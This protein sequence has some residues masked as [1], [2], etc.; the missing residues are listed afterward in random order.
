MPNCC[1][2][3]PE[4]P[5]PKCFA[6]VRTCSIY[7]VF[8][9][10]RLTLSSPSNTSLFRLLLPLP[11]S[12]VFSSFSPSSSSVYFANLT[13]V[14]VIAPEPGVRAGCSDRRVV[15]FNLDWRIKD[16]S[17]DATATRIYVVDE[18]GPSIIR[19]SL[20]SS[21]NVLD[22]GI[23]FD[24][25][26][27]EGRL[28]DFGWITGIRYPFSTPGNNVRTGLV[29]WLEE[30]ERGRRIKLTDAATPGFTHVLVS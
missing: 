30:D 12:Y 6:L 20:S 21:G 23:D 16:L 27:I 28:V 13:H 26:E 1:F 2:L 29:S 17:T 5:S 25:G 19:L 24:S 22:I 4:F 7:F 10:C 14:F 8:F 15:S 18:A 11:P 9:S 3:A